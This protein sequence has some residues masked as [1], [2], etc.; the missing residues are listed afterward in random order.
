[1]HGSVLQRDVFAL[2][3][4]VMARLD[5]LGEDMKEQKQDMKEVKQ[6]LGSVSE[7][8]GAM[9]QRDALPL[10]SGLQPPLRV[11]G[12]VVRSLAELFTLYRSWA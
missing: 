7:I 6:T 12:A 10:V 5:A 3:R 11:K 8:V 2:Q 9:A 4:D 1:M